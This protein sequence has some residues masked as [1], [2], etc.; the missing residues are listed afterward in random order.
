VSEKPPKIRQLYDEHGAEA[1]YRNH[2]E[3]YQNPHLPQVRVLLER[4][5]HRINCSGVVLDFAAGG[6][7]VTSVL[8]DLGVAETA[9]SDPFT[10]SLYTQQTGKPCEQWSFR[11]VL[12]QGLPHQYSAIICSFA[13]H[14]CPAKDLFL[15]TWN[16][17][18]AA[19]MLV[20][21]TPHKRPELELLPG[22]Q[23]DWQDI[24]EN[25][26]GKRVRIKCYS[27]VTG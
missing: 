19:P 24:T 21:L 12:L 16:L 8:H 15:L 2:A 1:Y 10:H 7:E 9:G 6:G 4:N 22:I 11:E 26:R 18:Q 13:L 3:A 5:L 20:I 23:L 27:L 25:D 14:L 17:L